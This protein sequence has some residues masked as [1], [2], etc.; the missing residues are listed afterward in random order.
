MQDLEF[1]VLAALLIWLL[2]RTRAAAQV[3]LWLR[4][5]ET[6]RAMEIES[7]LR[8]EGRIEKSEQVKKE[9]FESAK[10]LAEHYPFDLGVLYACGWGVEK[11]QNE[12]LRWYRK[13]AEQGDRRAQY[14]LAVAYFEGDGVPVDYTTA[15][16][17]LRVREMGNGVD[18][19]GERLS[20]EQR[21]E[22]DQRCRT[23]I[24]S[25]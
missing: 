6:S 20:P 1:L 11:D 12:A 7:K 10:I 14:N 17:W 23:W 15:Y 21:T 24:Q 22:V 18:V 4:A 16:F 5:S 25:R 9:E 3:S 19:V 13:A 8:L 2:W